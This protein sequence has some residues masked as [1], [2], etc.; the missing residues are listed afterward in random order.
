MAENRLRWFG[1]VKRRL[2]D[3]EKETDQKRWKK[4]KKF[5]K[6]TIKKDLE[7]KEFDPNMFYHRTLWCNFIYEVDLLWW[8]KTWLLLFVV[9]HQCRGEL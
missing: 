4:T 9:V 5:I 1:H 7:V 2:I 6:D 8:D 3:V